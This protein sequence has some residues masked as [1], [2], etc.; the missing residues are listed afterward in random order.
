M[1]WSSDDKDAGMRT[2]SRTDRGA[3]ADGTVARLGQVEVSTPGV[4][5][6]AA[7]SLSISRLFFC[8]RLKSKMHLVL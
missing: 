3:L 1:L 6:E 4:V 7:S 8:H 2:V 5:Q